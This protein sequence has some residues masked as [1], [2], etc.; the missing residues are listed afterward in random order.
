MI[1]YPLILSIVIL[2]PDKITRTLVHFT[3]SP[4]GSHQNPADPTIE[5][6]ATTR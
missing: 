3:D 1:I 5:P 2:I 4:H 6:Q